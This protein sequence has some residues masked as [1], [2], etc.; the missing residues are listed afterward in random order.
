M[1]LCYRRLLIESL[2]DHLPPQHVFHHHRDAVNAFGD[3][4]RWH[5][6]K[7]EP[8]RVFVI[9]IRE[10]GATRHKSDIQFKTASQN[11]AGIQSFRQ[12][13]P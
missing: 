12:L 4:I 5:I 10:K 13:N 9:S 2:L 7:I 1:G 3:A 11:D 6:R 8:Q